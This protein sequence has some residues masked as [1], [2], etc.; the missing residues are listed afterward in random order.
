MVVC[1]LFVAAVVCVTAAYA[2]TFGTVVGLVGG[3]SDIV[4]D[5]SRGRLYLVSSI[6]SR[7]EVYS[8]PQRRFLT[9]V[10]TEALPLAAA[11]SRDGRFLYVV[12]FDGSALNIV[13]LNTLENS[14]R[15]SLPAKPEGVAVGSDERVLIST[16]GT[17]ANNIA[18][19]LLIYD[20]NASSTTAL[21]SVPIAPAPPA[22]P[23][24]PPPSGRAFLASRSQLLASK[25]G[26]Y[27]VGVNIPNAASRAV[28]VYEVASGTVLRSR[29]VI[30]A[31]SVLSISPDNTRFMAGLHLFDLQTLQV[32]AQ[33]NT[34]NAPYPFQA[35]TNF[36][37]QQNQGGSIFSPDGLTVYSAFN[38]APFQNPPARPNVSQL[39]L[40]DP[41][42]L[43]IR[44]GLQLPEN[45]AGK[46]VISGDG[47]T[48]YAISESGIMILP[49]GAI[50]Q[51]PIAT[52]ASGAALL[53]NDQCGVFRAQR[54]AT[55]PIRNEGRGRLTAT[56]QLMQAAATPPGLGGI[57][58]P[59]GGAP[60]IPA[61]PGAAAAATSPVVRAQNTA[62]GTNIDFSYTSS[63]AGR[64][65]GTLSPSHMFVIQSNEAINIPSAVRVL[66]N[67]RDSESRGEVYAI[68][69]GLS[70][71]EALEDM[72]IDH[73]RQRLYIANSGLNR[74]EI[75]DLRSRS[76]LT[77][78]K[79]GQLPRSLAMT[80]DGS[81][82]YVAN[83]GGESI[84]IIDL[85]RLEL[86]GNVGFPALPFN[87]AAPLMTP[88]I[89]SVGLRGL[90]VIMN[91][92]TIWK[93]VGNEAVPRNL[94]PII[95][96]STIAAPRTM[97][98]TPGGEYILVVAG[99]G[100]VY[101]Y[102]SLAD[103]FVQGRQIFNNP[104]TGFYGPVAAGPRGQYYMV[105]GAILNQSLTPVASATGTRPISAIASAGANTLARFSQPLRANA[106]AVVTETPSVDILDAATGNMIRTAPALEGPVTPLVGN[107]RLNVNGR[108][109]AIDASGS[110]AYAIT[111]SGL[112]II[113]LD[114][115]DL[116][117]RPAINPNGTV[118]LSS[119]VP[120][121][122]PGSL[123][124]IFGRNLGASDTFSSTP[125]PVLMGG[126]CVTLNNQP[127]PLLMTSSGQINGQIPYELAPGR[128]PLVVRSTDR[129][130]GGLAQTIAV[131]RYAP[132][133]FAD[134]E[135]KRA[136]VFHRDGTLVGTEN[137]A[138]RDEPLVLYATGLGL[139]TGSR[140]N[141]GSPAPSDPLA[142]IQDLQVFFGDPR[143]K[144]AEVIV[145]WAG[146]TPGYVGVYQ[147]NLRVP[148]DHMRG[149]ELPVTLRIA[150][151]ESQKTGPAV[152][153]IAVD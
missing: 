132:A 13:D 30:G 93:V 31:S 29:S 150:G 42:N 125:L 110:N 7:I 106:A 127:V 49:I 79:A 76:L 135:T 103:E 81:I 114:Q 58:G 96:S 86:R 138:K 128:Y 131:S 10:S 69:T 78:V 44:L 75:F 25:D 126:A 146:L 66:Q 33:Q 60:G 129:K 104:I 63:A 149:A 107:G 61:P 102:D 56:A 48:I 88:S 108:T 37:I 20:P 111:A 124:S 105:N 117:D 123:I 115:P 62:E 71:N 14:T 90:Q 137:P 148:G 153:V 51:N 55:I 12:S 145:D 28:F 97:A 121:F 18:N 8:I 130:M 142:E 101:L 15:V 147:V 112:T 118:S 70:T 16:I 94:S 1:R 34:A 11:M 84:S 82:L 32:L 45:L 136:A 5:E 35:G 113:P 141:S 53:I 3:A 36:N 122:A 38:I 54:N 99:N 119:Y 67:F 83:T 19:T 133:V 65:P 9:T 24:L 92:G 17:G 64:S 2:A 85:D 22:N 68:P 73:G 95:G 134:P 27:I 46:M 40:N 47:S 116:R 6:Q 21:A 80:P 143:Y 109:L 50:S 74:V 151:V 139:T 41:D 39:M 52:P 89:I 4:L 59:G 23:L 77:P 91:N 140:V 87:S 43:L 72:V 144:Q 152:P 26:R 98:S 57:G 120:S 100:F